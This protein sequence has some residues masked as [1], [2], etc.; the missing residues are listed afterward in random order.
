M[1]DADTRA[2][3]APGSPWQVE[4]SPR[5]RVDLKSHLPFR[6]YRYF[7]GGERPLLV[8]PPI[9]NHP[10]ILDLR[11]GVSVVRR[12]VEH[13][14]EVHMVEWACAR[15]REIGFRELTGYLREVTDRLGP[16]P[17]FGYCTGGLAALLFAALHPKR[18]E[19]LSLLA[20]PVDFSGPD[21]RLAWARYFD[22]GLLRRVFR[23]IPG[24]A[25]NAVGVALLYWQ[26]PRLLLRAELVAE[27]TSPD[28]L[29]DHW[30]RLRWVLD[31]P[32][33]P[34]RAYEE[35]IEGCY[36]RNALIRNA[37][38]VG[39]KRV[40]LG[41]VE[42][43]VLNILADHD[44]IVPPESVR[45]LGRTIGSRHYD[46]IR[47]PSSHVGLTV[48]GRAH[49]ELWPRVARWLHEQDARQAAAAGE[50]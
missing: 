27:M 25:V 44:H 37:L 10:W 45:A 4:T 26:L 34:G 5:E 9:I 11:P 31:A 49:R 21:V 32:P 15:G 48:S 20:T 16:V 1:R 18:L 19:S 41:R 39:G 36:R 38:R 8:V 24:E 6:L 29:I 50:R 43:P 35:F 46:E 47:F 23:D 2:S 3:G 33:I 28:A 22:V 13:G 30:R 14:F 17:V 7:D 12:F 40:D 42:A